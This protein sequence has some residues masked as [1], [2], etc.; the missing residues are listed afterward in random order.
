MVQPFCINF[1]AFRPRYEH[2]LKR[3]FTFR[4]GLFTSPINY[5]A[6]SPLIF[7]LLANKDFSILRYYN[8]ANTASARLWKIVAKKYILQVFSIDSRKKLVTKTSGN[9]GE[10]RMFRCILRNTKWWWY[11]PAVISRRANWYYR[12]GRKSW[13][14]D[15]RSPLFQHRRPCIS[16]GRRRSNAVADSR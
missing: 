16:R 4:D 7:Y 1:Y 3:N 2:A 6:N 5:I 15:S 13:N 10:R 11:W 9:A 12:F 14:N 8:Y